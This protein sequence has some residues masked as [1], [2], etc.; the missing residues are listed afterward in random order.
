MTTPPIPPC[1]TTGL[2]NLCAP[3]KTIVA[4]AKVDAGQSWFLIQVPNLI[5]FLTLFAVILAGIL[6]QMPTR[7]IN[8]PASRDGDRDAG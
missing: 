2:I 4:G 7:P 1:E 5:W 3:A 6:I 8:G